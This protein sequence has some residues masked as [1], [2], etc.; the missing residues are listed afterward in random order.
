MTREILNQVDNLESNLSEASKLMLER[1]GNLSAPLAPKVVDDMKQMNSHD[2]E[3][4]MIIIVRRIQKGNIESY[5]YALLFKE[6]VDYRREIV[7][8]I[9]EDD[10]KIGPTQMASLKTMYV[11]DKSIIEEL[12]DKLLSHK[13][14]TQTIVDKIKDV[15]K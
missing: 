6:F 2:L 1:I 8:G 15:K 11:A 5:F 9:L 3:D 13:R 10:S 14:I 12:L 7:D 4:V